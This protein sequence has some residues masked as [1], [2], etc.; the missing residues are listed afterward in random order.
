M[1]GLTF[2]TNAPVSEVGGGAI[3]GMIGGAL[4]S[5]LGPEGS[6][7]GGAVGGAIGGFVGAVIAMGYDTPYLTVAWVDRDKGPSWATAPYISRQ[8]SGKWDDQRPNK[9][10]TIGAKPGVHVSP[11]QDKF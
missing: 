5:I 8:Y 2:E 3:G 4:G 10:Y 11:I 7:A 9:M 6:W 1:V